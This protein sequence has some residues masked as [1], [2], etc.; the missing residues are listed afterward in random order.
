[1]TRSERSKLDG[2]EMRTTGRA[3]QLG[4]DDHGERVV[5]ILRGDGSREAMYVKHDHSPAPVGDIEFVAHCR[6]DV[7]QLVSVLSLWVEENR[8][9]EPEPLADPPN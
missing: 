7:K 9:V 4:T 8:Q 5:M 3:W 6:E 2:L 1:M